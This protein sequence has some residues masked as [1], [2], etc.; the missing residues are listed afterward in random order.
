VYLHDTPSREL[1]AAERRTFSSGCIR[2]E[3]PLGLAQM[4]LSDQGYDKAKIDEV[5]AAGKTQQV[6]LTAP[7]PVLIV[8]WTVSVGAAGDIHYGPDV[9]DRDAR[10]LAALSARPG[11]VAVGT[12]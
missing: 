2:I 5:I 8:Y 4:L 6:N 12:P 9:Y 3:D 11:L 7:L 1:F 10:V